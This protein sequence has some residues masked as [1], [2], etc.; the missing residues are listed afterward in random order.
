MKIDPKTNKVLYQSHVLLG[1]VN[2]NRNPKVR[3]TSSRLQ[4]KLQE[5][6][7]K[8]INNI[9][10]IFCTLPRKHYKLFCI[11]IHKKNNKLIKILI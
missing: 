8:S 10:P 7:I 4:R 3:H 9:K 6:K 11:I 1:Q 5:K 2:R